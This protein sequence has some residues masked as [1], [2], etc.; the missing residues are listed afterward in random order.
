MRVELDPTPSPGPDAPPRRPA[1]LDSIGWPV[2]PWLLGGIFILVFALRDYLLTEGGVI[3]HSVYWGRDFIN[4]WTGGRLIASGRLDILYDL[5]AYVAAQREMFGDI[6]RHNYSYP[7]ISY[8][9]ALFFGSLPYPLALAGWTIGTAALFVHAA[10]PFWPARA[11][12]AWLA[13]LTPAALVNIWAGHYGFLIGALFLYGWRA[14]DTNPR[15]AG[16]FFGLMAVKPHLAVLIPIVLLFRRDWTAI[17]SAAL[18]VAALI[19]GSLLVWGWQPWHDFLFRTTALQAGMIDAGM[20]FFRLMS[21]SVATAALQLGWGWP[22]AMALQAAS[23]TAVVVGL[24]LCVRRG[25]APCGLA[26]L[27]AT[28]TFLF[29]PYAFNY[30]MTVVMI[31]ALAMMTRDD[32]T[33]T[34]LRFGLYGFFAPQVGMCALIVLHLPL[35]PAMLW[36]FFAMQLR[37]VLQPPRPAAA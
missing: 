13:A 29:L 31:A 7:P 35:M 9:I 33:L 24:Y 16:L 25:L 6:G 8:P 12:P 3:D 36:A 15:R 10:R 14:L 30:D 5:H 28:G 23:A 20:M 2:V 22:V 11:G 18:T 4:L 17:A 26:L 32:D 34:S 21:P 1:Y 19:G 37:L 27:V